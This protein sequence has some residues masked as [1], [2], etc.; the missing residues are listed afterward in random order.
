MM[1]IAASILIFLSPMNDIKVGLFS[2]SLG[3]MGNLMFWF[4]L[5]MNFIQEGTMKMIN[6]NSGFMAT[7][8]AQICIISSHLSVSFFYVSFPLPI[9][10]SCS[11]HDVALAY[12]ATSSTFPLNLA[13]KIPILCHA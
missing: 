1:H 12:L 11:F 2:A 8:M 4:T 7:L 6:V 9:C 10:W 13:L 5:V 3:F